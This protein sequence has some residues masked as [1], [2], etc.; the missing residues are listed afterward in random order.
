VQAGFFVVLLALHSDWL[1]QLMRIFF[2]LRIAPSVQ[3]DGPVDLAIEVDKLLRC[4]EVVAVVQLGGVG[5]IRQRVEQG[6]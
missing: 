4:A 2:A 3:R 6:G 5:R 1:V